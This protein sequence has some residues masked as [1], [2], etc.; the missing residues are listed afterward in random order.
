MFCN[1]RPRHPCFLDVEFD[2]VLQK[3]PKLNGK[4]TLWVVPHFFVV[5][6]KQLTP[7]FASRPSCQCIINKLN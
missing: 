6:Q 4:R 7:F 5:K 1:H 2:F 3:L